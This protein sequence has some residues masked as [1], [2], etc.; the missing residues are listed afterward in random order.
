MGHV[1]D[2][3]NIEYADSMVKNF[4]NVALSK[5]IIS[6]GHRDTIHGKIF[7]GVDSANIDKY[8]ES[9]N[10]F[11]NYEFEVLAAPL[12]DSYG[13]ARKRRPI[14]DAVGLIVRPILYGFSRLFN[15]VRYTLRDINQ[16]RLAV[17]SST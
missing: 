9:M 6:K 17:R 8:K 15:N 10:V 1:C 12:L 4:S 16:H 14:S 13:Y 7:S 3:L 5:S 2:F 11:E